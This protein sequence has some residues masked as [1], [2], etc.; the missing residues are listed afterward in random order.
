MAPSLSSMFTTVIT[1]IVSLFLLFVVIILVRTFTLTPRIVQAPECKKSDADFIPVD[2]A[3]LTRFQTALRFKTVSRSP[4]DQNFDELLKMQKFI[5][6]CK[7][8]LWNH[9]F[10]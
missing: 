5:V 7:L 6:S 9:Y 4:G 3:R 2:A 1:T 8:E 10:L